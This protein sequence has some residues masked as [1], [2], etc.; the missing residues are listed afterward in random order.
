MRDV[1]MTAE[2]AIVNRGAVTLAAD[3]AMTLQVR[4]AKKYIHQRIRS[5]SF[6]SEIR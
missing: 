5:L 2:I 4:G 6:P 1:R 3:S